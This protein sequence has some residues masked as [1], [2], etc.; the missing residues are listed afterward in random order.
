M[1]DDEIEAL[2][3]ASLRLLSE[4]GVKCY[5]PEARAILAEAGA[6]VDDATM[7][8]RLGRE[9]V[10]HAL[11]SVPPVIALVPR[12]PSSSVRVGGD[13]IVF[14]TVLGPPNCSDISSAAAAPGRWPITMIS[15][16]WRNSST[17]FI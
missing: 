9:L 6:L 13:D 1:S 4:I 3:E 15:C 17:S 8:V 12:N 2:H 16:G 5:S 10:E 7:R 11:T 14:A